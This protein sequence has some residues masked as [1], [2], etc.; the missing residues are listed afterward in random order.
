[1]TSIKKRRTVGLALSG[2][3]A[4]GFAHVGVL[5]ALQ[6]NQIPIDCVAGTSAGS[7][8][9]AAVAAGLNADEIYKFGQ[10][11]NWFKISR[12]S[13]STR[14]LVS[15]KG[16]K[17]L[18]EGQLSSTRFEDLKIPYA[19]VACDL[20]TCSE[21]VLKDKGDLVTAI[22]ASCAIPGVFTPVKD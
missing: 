14:G 10:G 18:I 7:F 5:K 15:N 2:G 9:G 6:D 21:V 17:T 13:Y 20:E 22:R 8:V 16:M 4:R 3:G 11:L 19:A 12:P 1:M